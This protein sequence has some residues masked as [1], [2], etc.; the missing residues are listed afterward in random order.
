VVGVKAK[1][2]NNLNRAL[3]GA[4]FGAATLVGYRACDEAMIW[5]WA[6]NWISPV[7]GAWVASLAW[8]ASMAWVAN[9]KYANLPEAKKDQTFFIFCL[10][11]IQYLRQITR[12]EDL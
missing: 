11:V 4:L 12:V 2:M 3:F 8:V 5:V 10:L 1:N 7:F 6:S 9:D